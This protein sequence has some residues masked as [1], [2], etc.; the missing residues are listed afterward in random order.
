MTNTDRVRQTI[1]R[2]DADAI[3]GYATGDVGSGVEELP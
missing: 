1:E 3:R 2:H